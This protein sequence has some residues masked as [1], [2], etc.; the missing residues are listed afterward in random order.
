MM[1]TRDAGKWVCR[2]FLTCALLFTFQNSLVMAA[3]W[4]V[5]DAGSGDGT[6][7][8]TPYGNIVAAVDA[9]TAGDEIWIKQGT[10]AIAS[11]ININKAI[12]LY[13]GFPDT[14]SPVLGDRDPILFPSTIDG[15]SNVQHC[16]D[17]IGGSITLDGLEI[18]GGNHN[19]TMSPA[20]YLGGGGVAIYTSHNNTIRNCKIYS[21]ASNNAAAGVAVYQST[22]T[23]IENCT[24]AS[25]A[26]GGT[27][28]IGAAITVWEASNTTVANSTFT[29]NTAINGGAIYFNP[30]LDTDALTITGSTFSGNHVVSNG[31]AL[32]LGY[33]NYSISNCQFTGNYAQSPDSNVKGGAIYVGGYGTG[34]GIVDCTFTNNYCF[35]W[36]DS[37]GG[38][39]AASYDVIIKRCDFNGNKARSDGQSTGNTKGGALY[40]AY[41]PSSSLISECIFKD[42]RSY[43]DTV[44]PT[45]WGGAMYVLSGSPKIENSLFTGNSCDQNGGALALEGADATINNSTFTENFTS[46]RGG[47]IHNTD[48]SPIISNTIFWNNQATLGGVSIYNADA[49]SLP[50]ISYTDIQS[51]GYPVPPGS[52]PGNFGSDP[53]FVTVGTYN[54]QGTT[55]LN[56]DIWTEGDYTLQA[57]SPCID[58]GVSTDMPVIDLVSITRPQGTYH[59]LGSYE[60]ENSATVY[61]L[62][63]SVNGGNGSVTPESGRYYAA[64]TVAVSLTASPDSHY[65]VDSWTGTADDSS[66]LNTNSV[67]MSSDK[68]VTVSFAI[69]TFA[70]SYTTDGNGTI[71]GSASQTIDYG[72]DGA[73][74]TAVAITG[75][76]FVKWS[77]D[78]M[79]AAR[80]DTS[81]TEDL[82]VSASFIINTYTLDYTAGANGTISGTTPQTVDYDTSGTAVTAIPNTGYDFVDWDDGITQISRTDTN[83]TSDI[84][85]IAN[86]A[87][88]TFALNY[89]AGANGSLTGATFQ[90]VDYDT[91]GSPVTAEAISGYHFVDWSDG[92]I[93]NPR[94]DTHVI[95]I[96]D[97]TANF[98]DKYN[99]SVVFAG[100]GAGTV[101]STPVGIDNCTADCSAEFIQGESV[102][103]VAV[104]TGKKGEFRGWSGDGCTGTGDCTVTMDQAR[105][106]TAT[107]T[108]GLPWNMFLPAIL[109]V[110][111]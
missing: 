96:V 14:G 13:G 46:R 76:S 16:L 65:N 52:G 70:L 54:S 24:F 19:T 77:D 8:A 58:T 10:Y 39:V 109:N 20:H 2:V 89:T 40:L 67:T 59:D 6:S 12:T 36:R 48:S 27:G 50:W 99:L 11:T 81:V 104:A 1:Q 43:A 73:L 82:S 4:Y 32:Y 42:N 41:S 95:A 80:T 57:S 103:L 72:G 93:Q 111:L 5:D 71:S 34:S 25:N 64:D 68:T 106:I 75:Y 31:G 86:F 23:T 62:S 47:A 74:V 38:A 66:V 30:K 61:T 21:N 49:T 51:Y 56:D 7:W 87:I 100:K 33:G 101:T 92:S 79:I 105:E 53:L 97:V 83:V 98:S 63:A 102:T 29:L 108:N 3:T 91:A 94:T 110:K 60:V 90:Q 17:L 55:T 22:G 26:A 69:E 45:E 15:Q 28:G 9:A 85:V 107:F 84:D 37:W 35:G 44:T 18:T 88:K 78:V